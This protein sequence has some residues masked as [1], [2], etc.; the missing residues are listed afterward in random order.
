M[1]S[2]F[3]AARSASSPPPRR[4]SNWP[5]GRGF[6]WRRSARPR[7][8]RCRCRPGDAPRPDGRPR[9]AWRRVAPADGLA[10]RG[11]QI[12]CRS[13][14]AYPR[15][16]GSRRP[17]GCPGRAPGS[18]PRRPDAP[19]PEAGPTRPS[20]EKSDD[21]HARR[22]GAIARVLA[23][24]GT[25]LG[26][27]VIGVES[28]RTGAGLPLFTP[29]AARTSSNC[30]GSFAAESPGVGLLV[31]AFHLYARGGADG[32]GLVAGRRVGR[33]GPRRR[34]A[35]LGRTADRRSIATTRTGACRGRTGRSTSAGLLPRLAS[36]ATRAPSRPSR[37]V[38]A[39]RWRGST[40]GDG[41]GG[42][43]GPQTVWPVASPPS[44]ARVD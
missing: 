39:D 35:G 6:G 8:G 43:D 31:D 2:S 38:V 40:A 30:W 24:H 20:G 33:L 29:S 22:L 28:A 41:A 5:P 16:R 21:L 27:E 10:G 4:R 14:H 37:W 23:D 26:L 13:P 25:R 1:F 9:P 36:G 34:P 15:W 12:S 11:G 7:P 32:G 44:R 42:R 17:W 18:C 19:T 3:N